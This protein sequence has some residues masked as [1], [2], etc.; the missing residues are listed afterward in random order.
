MISL[1]TNERSPLGGAVHA[2]VRAFSPSLRVVFP[3]PSSR[4]ELRPTLLRASCLSKLSF[5][6]HLHIF[7]VFNCRSKVF[8]CTFL[9]S[10]PIKI[11]HRLLF[12]FWTFCHSF[13][14]APLELS[15]S[16]LEI[17][18]HKNIRELNSPSIQI[19]AISH[20]TKW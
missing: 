12:N 15:I 17:S 19:V 3:G 16:H 13:H 10:S 4:A 7:R 8:K 1:P 5:L 14:S 9:T 6:S 18:P 11:S 20:I 2:Q